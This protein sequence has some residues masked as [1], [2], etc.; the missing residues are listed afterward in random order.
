MFVKLTHNT[1]PEDLAAAKR[2]FWAWKEEFHKIWQ[3][4]TMFG[5]A[6]PHFG[7]VVHDDKNLLRPLLACSNPDEM[8]LQWLTNDPARRKR[9]W[10]RLMLN[11]LRFAPSRA[12][13][14]FEAT[15]DENEVPFYAMPDVFNFLVRAYRLLPPA[16]KKEVEAVEGTDGFERR[17]KAGAHLPRLVL[18]VL[19]NSTPGV[20]RF[21]QDQLYAAAATATT[22]ELLHLYKEIKRHDQQ[23][24]GRTLGFWTKQ[25][26]SYRFSKHASY[27]TV[28][29]E[30]LR[31][32]VVNH[33]LDLSRPHGA[34][35]CTSILHY[36][37]ETA[38]EPEHR[39][40]RSRLFEQL[41][42]LGL[43][44]NQITFTAII[45]N[46]FF[47]KDTDRAWQL[48][49][50]M[51]SLGIE[52]DDQLYSILIQ[53]SKLNGDFEAIARTANLL[54]SKRL[55][56]PTIWNDVIHCIYHAYV[57]A[58]MESGHLSPRL[59]SAFPTMFQ[60]YCKYFDPEPL[61]RVLSLYNPNFFF[62]DAGEPPETAEMAHGYWLPRVP[63]FVESLQP[64]EE[65]ERLQPDHLTLAMMMCGY[66]KSLKTPRELIIFYST[67]RQRL[68]A[69][70]E[71]A[72]RIV[73]HGSEVHDAV[74]MAI[75]RCR[76][77]LPVA[78]DILNDMLD[79]HT[80]GPLANSPEP[81][82]PGAPKPIPH[83]RPSAHTWA[84]LIKGLGLAKQPNRA[85][86]AL[87]TM[88]GQGDT[89]DNV[90]W[91]T[92][93]AGYARAQ[94]IEGVISALRRRAAAGFPPD[95]YTLKAFGYLRSPG[96]AYEKMEDMVAARERA[97]EREQADVN[98][99]L[100]LKEEALGGWSEVVG[101]P[102]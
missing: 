32:L 4:L 1:P 89:P 53:G 69:G 65:H 80:S 85:E 30:I 2:R 44:P 55:P 39:A 25:Q 58:F 28:A 57:Q 7:G 77:M 21:T 96:D 27:K 75:T 37:E 34:A 62:P 15:F 92:V 91:N 100:G 41:L 87:R 22:N 94:D 45:R 13:E 95:E 72:G 66:V 10:T 68:K 74:L 81:L 61:K 9:A 52:P 31:D 101:G 29:M 82:Q 73:A 64:L 43:R 51:T 47:A 76:G 84:A 18:H 16:L 36:D 6:S 60:V 8:R 12:H 49:D 79:S 97:L 19:R 99:V 54:A 46:M 24:G 67:F 56:N 83:P 98:E 11:T 48:F 59:L 17:L 42:D 33:K 26:F 38:K 78:L 23:S 3:S 40:T 5:L 63:R 71:T 14:F 88:Q 102:R 20:F 35:L 70:D 93:A 86:D 90:H 50:Y